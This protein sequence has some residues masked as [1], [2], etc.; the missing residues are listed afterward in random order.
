MVPGLGTENGPGVACGIGL[1]GSLQFVAHSAISTMDGRIH[2]RCKKLAKAYVGTVD[3][4][5]GPREPDEPDPE[6]AAPG[7]GG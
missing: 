4:S 7:Q 6:L 2:E 5:P 1:S 3:H